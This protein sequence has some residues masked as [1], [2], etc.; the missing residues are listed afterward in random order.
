[1]ITY[2][3]LAEKFKDK[4]YFTEFHFL[5]SSP[6]PF[7]FFKAVGTIEKQIEIYDKVIEKV[8][9]EEFEY[10]NQWIDHQNYK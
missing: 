10:W 7:K 5:V 6:H 9:G 8:Y 1:M 2:Q 4:G 3:D